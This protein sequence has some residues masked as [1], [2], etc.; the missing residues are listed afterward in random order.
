LKNK[1]RL[2]GAK[3]G[4]DEQYEKLVEDIDEVYYKEFIREMRLKYG[5]ITRSDEHISEIQ[6]YLLEW[7]KATP[8]AKSIA[9][10]DDES[11]ETTRKTNAHNPAGRKFEKRY[12]GKCFEKLG[13]KILPGKKIRICDTH[14]EKDHRDRPSTGDNKP[15]S[16]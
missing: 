16:D 14:D 11:M 6:D 1:A 9:K 12:C 2:A 7:W 10:Q 15:T 3:I 8:G 13:D 4:I 5:K